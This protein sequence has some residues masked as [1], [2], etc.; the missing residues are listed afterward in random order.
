MQLPPDDD[1]PVG[2]ITR[3]KILY[4][5]RQCFQNYLACGALNTENYFGGPK[6][7]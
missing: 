3:K 7:H 5:V 1:Q 6:N 2:Q 4:I